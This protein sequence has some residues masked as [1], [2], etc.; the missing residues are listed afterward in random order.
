MSMRGSARAVFA[1]LVAAT[2]VIVGLLVPVKA[3]DAATRS[4]WDA[5]AKCE[6]GG[7]WSINTGNG[8]YGGLQFSASTWRAHG[9]RG[10]ASAATRAEQ[11]R[12]GERVV[13]SQG[14]EAW[15]GCAARLGLRGRVLPYERKASA[16]ATRPR[17]DL[18]ILAVGDTRRAGEPKRIAAC[19]ART[20]KARYVGLGSKAGARYADVELI[21]T[22]THRCRVVG[23]SR[24]IR[25]APARQDQ[26][27]GTIAAASV[28]PASF[29]P[30]R[31]SKA[32]SKHP[33]LVLRAKGGH[34]Y[35][36]IAI[37]STADAGEQCRRV[38]VTMV[39]GGSSA[40]EPSL[41]GLR[42]QTCVTGKA[43]R[44][45]L[46]LVHPRTARSSAHR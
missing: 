8:Y 32:A 36:R 9:G 24:S 34:A 7:N 12:I 5:I 43:E 33:R 29:T 19:T 6:S 14:W 21:N 37:R 4:T 2:L 40:I 10:S 1:V 25:P 44:K 28:T 35:S 22:G 45:V 15:A 41:R 27:T 3:A 26:P 38:K 17:A 39:S 46:V 20:L 30:V 31:L 11:I 18:S 16:S 13:A 42:L 23:A